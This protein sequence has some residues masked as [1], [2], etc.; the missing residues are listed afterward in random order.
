MIHFYDKI[1]KSVSIRI[2]LNQNHPADVEEAVIPSQSLL[3]SYN[4]TPKFDNQ[5]DFKL[6]R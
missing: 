1:L 6:E 3:L 4:N 5:K 2:F